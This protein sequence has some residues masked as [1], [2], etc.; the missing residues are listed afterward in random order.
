MQARARAR[1]LAPPAPHGRRLRLTA[2]AAAATRASPSCAPQ[3][4]KEHSFTFD[5]S[6]WSMDPAAPQFASQEKVYEDLGRELL[7]HAFA[8][9]NTCL[10]A[11]GQ[12]G[13]GKSY[14]MMGYGEE[15]GLIPRICNELFERIAKNTNPDITYRIEVRCAG[16][17]ACAKVDPPA[18]HSPAAA[19]ALPSAAAA[20]PIQLHGDLLRARPRS[21]GPESARQP[22]RARASRARPVCGGPCQDGRK[23]V[24]RH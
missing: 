11:Y 6:Y 24:R 9:Y 2:A 1:A 20:L 18:T 17:T 3:H 13:S 19:R 10:F 23:L 16:G 12:T 5:H 14:T 21:A 4:N 8:G 22:A 7:D 15:V